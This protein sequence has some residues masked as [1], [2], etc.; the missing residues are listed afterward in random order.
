MAGGAAKGET[1]SK[2]VRPSTCLLPANYL[3]PTHL[4]I[5]LFVCLPVHLLPTCLPSSLE[6]C[7]MSTGRSR[8]QQGPRGAHGAA[9]G[10]AAHP[11]RRSLRPSPSQGLRPLQHSMTSVGSG[12]EG[13]PEV[14][15]AFDG[16]PEGEHGKCTAAPLT[17]SETSV[18]Q[19]RD[20]PQQRTD[21]SERKQKQ[22]PTMHVPK[23]PTLAPSALVQLRDTGSV[24]GCPRR[25]KT[26][27]VLFE[28]RDVPVLYII[29][30]RLHRIISVHMGASCAQMRTGGPITECPTLVL[31]GALCWTRR[32]F[33]V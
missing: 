20:G 2:N 30:D 28:N 10:R 32:P 15:R 12:M 13:G 31:W 16:H 6:L 27:F 19:G 7:V 22:A 26:R 29:Q 4:L 25:Q 8:R 1:V 18:A 23:A 21:I 5:Y 9:G 11:P 24:L 3:L 33:W 17:S 14:E